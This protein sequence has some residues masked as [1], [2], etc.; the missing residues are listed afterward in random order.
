M[1]AARAAG[2]GG[3]HAA[4]SRPGTESAENVSIRT[5]VQI[6]TFSADSVPGRPCAW[7][8]VGE[9]GTV[10]PMHDVRFRGSIRGRSLAAGIVALAALACVAPASAWVT[11]QQVSQPELESV[12]YALATG[13][14]G[15]TSLVWVTD[16]G[17]AATLKVASRPAAGRFGAPVTASPIDDTDGSG[18]GIAVGPDGSTTVAWPQDTT[19]AVYTATRGPGAEAFGSPQMLDPGGAPGPMQ[20]A[21]GDD[22]TTLVAWAYGTGGGGTVIRAAIRPPGASAFG[23]AQTIS[24][25]GH[26]V[27]DPIALAAPDGSLTV[28]WHGRYGG[29]NTIEAA[30]RP[31]GGT[32]FSAVQVIATTGPSLSPTTAVAAAVGGDGSVTVVWGDDASPAAL[33]TAT[34]PAGATAF[35]APEVVPTTDLLPDSAYPVIAVGPDGAVAIAWLESPS[36]GPGSTIRVAVRPAGATSFRAAQALAPAD[37]QSS[38]L[39]MA[40]APDGRFTVAWYEGSGPKTAHTA[41]AAP[42]AATFTDVEAVDTGTN[43]M[44]E[45]ALVAA[46]DGTPIM[47]WN[48]GDRGDYRVYATWGSPTTYPLTTAKTGTGTGTVT[49]APT[50]IDCGATCSATLTLSTRVTLTAKPTGGS[51]FAGWSGACSGTATTCVVPILG[52]RTATARFNGSRPGK[53]RIARSRTTRDLAEIVRWQA[54]G[55]SGG[56]PLLRYQTR[57]RVK[58]GAWSGWERQDIRAGRKVQTRRFPGLAPGNAY[59]V[60]IRAVNRIGPGRPVLVSFVLPPADDAP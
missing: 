43:Q 50:G 8:P 44:N 17:Y 21:A 19:G 59:A 55:S 31:A 52:A 39:A 42:G 57:Y 48:S 15:T 16:T 46:I 5:R 37:V 29:A 47:A 38:S 20:V 30:T 25:A 36:P 6:S 35:G 1:T 3:Y 12:A 24:D 32:T 4:K 28:L 34:R 51:T 40:V 7:R 60:E 9:S 33:R 41:T 10:S 27:R 49:S 45:P 13:T 2:N 18:L 23:T 53:V 56:T 14:D 54:P 11:P 58:G 22:G 26:N